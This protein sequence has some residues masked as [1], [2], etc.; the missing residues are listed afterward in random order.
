[1]KILALCA[2]GNVRSASLSATLRF[3]Y[4]KDA[5]SAGLERNSTE[6]LLML[7][8]WADRI[9]IME[10]KMRAQVP[11]RFNPKLLVCEVGPDSYGSP[12]NPKLLQMCHDFIHREGLA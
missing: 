5:L 11:P 9:V 1:M 10:E 3:S 12:F 2:A 7:M 4:N 6:T 8:E